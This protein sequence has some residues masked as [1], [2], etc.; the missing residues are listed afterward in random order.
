MD[1]VKNSQRN[2]ST[3]MDRLVDTLKAK[4][5]DGVTHMGEKGNKNFVIPFSDSFSQFLI[6]LNQG[7]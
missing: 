5:V 2:D 1:N 4:N 7:S 6:W 3:S